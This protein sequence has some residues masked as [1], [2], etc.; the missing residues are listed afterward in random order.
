MKCIMCKMCET[1]N[2]AV[3]KKLS[4]WLDAQTN[5]RAIWEREA[6]PERIAQAYDLLKTDPVQGFKE[7][8]AL[9]EQGSVWSMAS[10]GAAFQKG[11]GTPPDLAQA[12]KWYRRAYDGGSDHGLLWLGQLYQRQRQ[13]AKAEQVY[14]TGAERG[15][16]PAMCRLAWVYSKSPAWPQKRK[17]ALSLLERASAAGDLSARHFLAIAMMRGWF[18]LR[19]IPEG[20]RLTVKVSDDLYELVKDEEALAA[21]NDSDKP[22]GFFSRLVQLFALGIMRIPAA[23][24]R[25]D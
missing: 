14:R 2:A 15:W 7:Y 25:A 10:V 3:D 6:D 1:A 5:E 18:G 8:L 22:P 19:R 20:I 9:A 11:L 23:Q 17:E 12:E 4:A 16:A 13:Y 24:T 21:K